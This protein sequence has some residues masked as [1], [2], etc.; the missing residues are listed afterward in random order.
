[1]PLEQS[2]RDQIANY[3][4]K[5]LPGDVNWHIALFDFIAESNMELKK[6][7]GRAFYSAR[8]MAKLMEATHA[9]K[10]ELHAFVKFQIIQYASIYEAVVVYLLR[11]T[12]K[13]HTEVKKLCTHKAYK[14]MSALGSKTTMILDGEELHT[15]VY[16]D[17]QTPW[18][19]I[20]FS[21]KVDCAVR[22]GFLEE[23]YAEDIK[24]LYVLRNLAHLET[25][26]E[27][28]IEVQIEQSKNGYWRLKPF[29]EK[30]SDFVKKPK[31]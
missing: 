18:S 13:D 16:R 1:M 22:I 20:S 19:S 26:A 10:D 7:L 11:E 5:D 30:V 2:I 15:C 23:K 3:C 6:R 9:E 12:F 17:A 14:K 4:A 8:F 24:S 29:L 31:A 21:D 28:E 27:K 25:E